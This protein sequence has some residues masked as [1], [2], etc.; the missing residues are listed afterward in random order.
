MILNSNYLDGGGL[1]ISSGSAQSVSAAVEIEYSGC[2][3][4][5]VN[6]IMGRI[7]N[8]ILIGGN[9]ANRVGILEAD[10]P[11]QRTNRPEA[12]ENNVFWFAAVS[13]LTTDVMWRQWNGTTGTNLTTIAQVNAA[14]M[15]VATANLNA[16]PMATAWHLAAGSPCI[17]TGTATE[18]PAKDMDGFARPNGGAPDIGP[19]EM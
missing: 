18:S 11:N 5:G 17:D 1:A 12:V 3:N 13:G 8:N 10:S 14:T 16:D 2:G 15:P 7:R 9:G 6:A 4:C 19:D